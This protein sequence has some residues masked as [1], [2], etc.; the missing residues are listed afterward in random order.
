MSSR[1]TFGADLSLLRPLQVLLELGSVSRAAEVLGVS[2]PAMS[3]VLA[4]LRDQFHDPLMVRG[5]NGMMLT[6][7]AKALRAPL[8]KW[9]RDA[10][11]L[12]MPTEFDPSRMK[13]TFRAASSDFGI[14]SV[15]TPAVSRLETEA[16]DCSVEI[17][18]LTNTSLQKLAEDRLD[19]VIT[20][21]EPEGAGLFSHRLFSDGYLGVARSDHPIHACQPTREEL[22][23][24][25]HV[26][27]NV[28][29]GLGDWIAEALPEIAF[30][31]GVLH[32]NSFAV[33]PY[34]V[35]A[36]NALA[37]LPARAA[38]RFTQTHDL[39]AFTLPLDFRPLDYFVV[40]HERSRGDPAMSWLIELLIASEAAAPA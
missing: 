20:G 1:S 37:I 18:P 22:L 33:T 4:R 10:D 9:L 29:E 31:R 8:Q 12:L 16:P 11:R 15:V 7:R 25:P 36:G 6:P 32:S 38:R 35:A 23:D 2:Q 40:W 26:V 13:V 17:E 3:R 39:R 28:G 30:G 14:L 24:W 19:I 5:R 21:Y 34:M 27:T